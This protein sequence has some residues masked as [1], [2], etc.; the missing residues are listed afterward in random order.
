MRLLLFEWNGLMQHDLEAEL[1]RLHIDFFRFSYNFTDIHHDDYFEFRFSQHLSKHSYDAV[2]SFNYFPAVARICYLNNL[3][4]ISWCYDS[5]VRVIPFDTFSYPTNY[6]FMFDKKEVSEYHSLGFHNIYHLPLAVNPYR[7]A[8]LDLTVSDF[9]KYSCDISFVG[10][11]HHANFMDFLSVLPDYHR[12]YL[13]SIVQAQSDLREVF[14]P[15]LLFTDDY[16]KTLNPFFQ[17]FTNNPDYSL[18]KENFSFLFGKYI[19]EKERYKYLTILSN[20]FL[21]KLFSNYKP[22]QLDNIQYMGTAKYYSEMSKIFALSKINFNS[23]FYCIRTGISL[24]ILDIL[25][26]GGFLLTNYQ[27]ELFDYFENEVHLVVYQS[28]IDAFEKCRFYL[29]HESLREQIALNGRRQVFEHF[30]YEKQLAEIFKISE[31]N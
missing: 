5:P 24:R 31:L 30:S 29:K 21:T 19:T 20:H 4:Y 26:A 8:L 2:F 23:S 16:M 14:L 11:F 25:G 6:I 1:H 9:E 27:E 12:G 7:L 22:Q 28:P 17:Q 3:K 18:S 15:D 13:Q 10:N